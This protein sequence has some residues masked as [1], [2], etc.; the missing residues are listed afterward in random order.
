[1]SSSNVLN[2]VL[3]EEENLSP[4]PYILNIVFN[5]FSHFFGSGSLP[6]HEGTIFLSQSEK[7]KYLTEI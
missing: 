1:M 4:T 3:R 2:F 7:M 5:E 6:H